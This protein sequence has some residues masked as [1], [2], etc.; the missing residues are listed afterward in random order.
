MIIR[1]K[2]VLAKVTLLPYIRQPTRASIILIMYERT[3]LTRILHAVLV[4]VIM[5]ITMPLS[6]Q[7][8]TRIPRVDS[9]L[10]Y[11]HERQLFNG[12]ILLAEK[13]KVI[14]SKAFG[15]SGPDGKPLTLASAFNL[16]SVSKQFY[17]MM[18][19]MLKEEKKVAYD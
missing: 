4:V 6:A 3:I 2:M 5:T 16:A 19:M 11:L 15:V 14:Y 10:T 8:K 1:G 7:W 9:V 13:G 12:T 18:I 17:A